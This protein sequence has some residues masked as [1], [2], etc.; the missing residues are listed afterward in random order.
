VKKLCYVAT[1]PAAVHAFLRG[2]IQA[3]SKNYEVTVICNSVDKYLLDGLNARLIL[4]PIERKPSPWRD[5]VA[6]FKMYWLFRQERFDIVHSHLPKTGL[7]GMLAAWMARVPVRINTFHGEVWATRKGWRR[8]GL[9][10][11]D[12]LVV[13]LATDIMVVS[14]SQ[15]EFLVR[16]DVLAS[17][18][19]RIIGAGSICGV[20]PIRFAPNVESRRTIRHD[21]GIAQD[22]K[23]ILFVGRLNRDKGLLDL[24]A[25]F[26]N[27]SLR[28]P[29]V[30]LL[31]V[32]AEEEIS[33]KD[34]QEICHEVRDRLHYVSFTS[35]PEQFMA[36]ADIF[37][38]PSFREGFG[39]TII[40]AA[41]CGLPAVATRIYGITDAIQLGKTGLLVTPGDV[42]SLTHALSALINDNGLRET[43]GSAARERAFE[44]FSSEMITH[45]MEMLYDALY[46]RSVGKNGNRPR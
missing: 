25:A 17:G 6:L 7:L 2:H 31:L 1:I 22:A 30:E 45:E 29:A 13:W 44:L 27:I 40:E 41:A 21:M 23:V 18:K 14:P 35:K 28:N 24:A 19:A 9:K 11:F 36:A 12:K 34:I 32:G 42:T 38:L 3:V 33:F 15:R 5:L 39:V 16:E 4:L 43:M 26:N 8:T 20:D 37:C 46:D 10:L